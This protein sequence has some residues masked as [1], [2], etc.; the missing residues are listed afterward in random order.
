MVKNQKRCF[1]IW[2]KTRIDAK[3]CLRRLKRVDVFLVSKKSLF[4]FNDKQ[5]HIDFHIICCLAITVTSNVK[6]DLLLITRVNKIT[7][8]NFTWKIC[9]FYDHCYRFF[10]YIVDRTRNRWTTIRLTVLRNYYQHYRCE[11]SI[12]PLTPVKCQQNYRY[13]KLLLNINFR[14]MFHGQKYRRLILKAYFQHIFLD[15]YEVK[16]VAFTY[17]YKLE[18]KHNI[19]FWICM[20]ISYTIWGFN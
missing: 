18:I 2:E 13:K 14:F 4:S 5:G 19:V 7:F 10:S 17:K 12:Q 16:N 9:N 3:N 8:F 20:Q 11:R 6:F 15:K 1:R